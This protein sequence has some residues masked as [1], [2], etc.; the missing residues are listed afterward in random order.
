[1]NGKKTIPPNYIAFFI[2]SLESPE[3]TN[4]YLKLSGSVDFH[5]S[6]ALNSLPGSCVL[7]NFIYYVQ[8]NIQKKTRQMPVSFHQR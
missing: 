3:N 5:L 7:S 8:G 6:I 2:C 4:Y 1:M